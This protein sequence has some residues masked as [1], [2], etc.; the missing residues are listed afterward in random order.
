MLR[1]TMWQVLD[2][3]F[4][5]IVNGRQEDKAKTIQT[6]LSS[7]HIPI[8]SISQSSCIFLR[9]YAVILLEWLLPL[10]P[11]HSPYHAKALIL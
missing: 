8:F 7:P 10:S 4:L 9:S 3:A 1:T 2:K 5:V 11:L 6:C